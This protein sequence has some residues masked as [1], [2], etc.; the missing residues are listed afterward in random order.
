MKNGLLLLFITLFFTAC[1]P[2][3]S[4]KSL[5]SSQLHNPN[6]RQLAVLNFKNDTI[7]QSSSVESL[8]SNLIIENKPYFTLVQ[9]ENL[10]LILNEKKLNDSALVEI[11]DLSNLRGLTE[12]KT[13]LLGD[14]I[15]STMYQKV[16]YRTEKN[17]QQC[18]EYNKNKQCIRFPIVYTRCQTNDYS[19]QTQIKLVEII[20]SDILFSQ[21]YTESDSITY[22]S[23]NSNYFPSKQEHNAYLAQLIAQ[24]ILKDIAPH[25][26][27]FKVALLEDLDIY[28]TKEVVQQFENALELLKQGRFDKAQGLLEDLNNKMHAE[29]YVILYNL[30]LC[31]EALNQI[32]HA[33]LLY[34]KAEDI[35]LKKEIVEEISEAIVRTA[36]NIEEYKKANKLLNY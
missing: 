13:F 18:L 4:I 17:Y 32:E 24:R 35:S 2:K 28:T 20:T 6:I 23:M 8:L 31:Y 33:H 16:Y 30:A 27:T 5:H 25:Y 9:R 10:N 7:G 3:I 12:V 14:V 34:Q 21:T 29:S 1:A 15:H 19:V 22:C 36:K 26:V 11:D